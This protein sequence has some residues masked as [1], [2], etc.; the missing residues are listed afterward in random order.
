MARNT[1]SLFQHHDGITGTA[2]TFVVN[3]YGARFVIMN[4]YCTYFQITSTIVLKYIY[5]EVLGLMIL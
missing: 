2:K 5:R 1:L 4:M 3:D